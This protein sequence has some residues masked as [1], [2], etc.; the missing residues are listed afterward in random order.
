M[1]SQ[2]FQIDQ[3]ET[4]DSYVISLGGEL[5][6]SVVTQLR[7]ALEPVMERADLNL[8]LNLRELTY[9]DSTGIGIIVSILK[10]R[11]GINAPFAVKEI[12]PSIQRLFDLTGIS[13]Y[14]AEGTDK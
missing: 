2:Q 8:V 6:L 9:I 1:K 4:S 5:D 7:S 14:L 10:Y 13:G 3:K 12:P 11:D